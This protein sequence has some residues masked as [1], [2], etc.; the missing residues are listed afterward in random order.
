MKRVRPPQ[1]LPSFTKAAGAVLLETA[2]ALH[3]PRRSE[4]TTPASS[5]HLGPSG[6]REGS[7]GRRDSN[8]RLTCHCDDHDGTLEHASNPAR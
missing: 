4:P 8:S 2:G 7:P 1:P 3:R 5:R 6:F